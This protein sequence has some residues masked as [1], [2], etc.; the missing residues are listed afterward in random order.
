[1]DSETITQFEGLDELE[2]NGPFISPAH[3]QNYLTTDDVHEVEPDDFEQPNDEYL[4][5]AEG[6]V[7]HLGSTDIFNAR[8]EAEIAYEIEQQVKTA[9]AS[10]VKKPEGRTNW[11]KGVLNRVLGLQL[12]DDNALDT[13]TK[14][15]IEDFQIKQHLRKSSQI[16]SATE[17]ALLEE[18]ALLRSKST[19]SETATRSIVSIA[20]TKIEDWTTKAIN[21]KPKHILNSYRDPRKVYAFVLHQMAFKRQHRKTK[22]YS[23]P[24]SYLATGA[25]FCIMF[26]GRIVQ[27]HPCSRMIWHGNCLS[28]GS[29]AVEFEGN[30]P[31]V[32]GRWWID[33]DSRVQNKDKPTQAQ[34]E[35]GRFLTSY[36]KTVM[37]ITHVLAHRQSSDSRENDPGPDIWYQIG[38]WALEKL[39]LSDG[40]AQFKCGTGNPILPAWRTWNNQTSTPPAKEVTDV[41]HNHECFE[42]QQETDEAEMLFEEP[43]DEWDLE[44]ERK[45]ATAPGYD[46]ESDYETE[47]LVRDWTEAV[48][49][50]RYYGKKIGWDKYIVEIND[51]LLPYSGMS[52]VSLGEDAFAAAV[53]Q[54]QT[55]N[56]FTGNNIDGIIGPATWL[57]MQ[58]TLNLPGKAAPSTEAGDEVRI[59]DGVRFKRKK[60]GWA[61][62]GGGPLREKLLSLRQQGK[63]QITPNEIEMFRLVSIPESGGLVN[64]INSWDDMFMSMGFLQLTI[65]YY[66]LAQVI[67]R[68]PEAFKKH[69]IELDPERKYFPDERNS[70]AIKNAPNI[71][72]LRSFDW[73]KRFYNAGLEDD[74]II[75]QVEVGRTILRTIRSRFDNNNYLHRFNDQS[76]NLW[77]FIYEA[78]NSRPAPFNEA[79]KAAI[80]Q[81]SASSVGDPIKFGQLL[82]EHLK[83]TTREYY[84]SPQRRYS[85]EE[86]K[87]K[88]IKAELAKVGR[89]IDK[90]G[91]L[92]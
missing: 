48:R 60:N 12:P 74:A 68:A 6:N 53:F 90:T 66:E 3:S 1:M 61:A 52:N 35:S 65:R 2:T 34:F 28:P 25:H 91:I 20:K 43:Q 73:A 78:H 57:A 56:G 27:L 50:N 88:R 33:K 67:K 84:G 24:E 85:S 16:D 39:G 26:D 14:K 40:G 19:V 69:G 41:S 87:Q 72:D 83:R 31:N 55:K 62:Y 76:P 8:S 71:T 7:P 51:M 4:E 89:I 30:F 75:A 9:K 45:T 18:D 11:A 42:C 80:I 64:A 63:L 32:K 37:G 38:Q 17:R 46:D 92:K 5:Q 15:A 70:I 86:Q 36:L 79:L 81:A 22:K 82:I 23:D 54:W 58:K 47:Y 59:V 13:V 49:G 29:V 77:A 21:N 10:H 44:S